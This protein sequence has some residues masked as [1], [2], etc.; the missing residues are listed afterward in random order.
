MTRCTISGNSGS[1]G[2]GLYSSGPLVMTSCT[3]SGNSSDWGGGVFSFADSV[4]DTSSVTTTFSDCTFSGN[5]ASQE[6]GGFCS[7]S[8]ASGSDSGPITT[9]FTDC[10]FS[11]N[12]A[13]GDFGGGLYISGE[14][15]ASGDAPLSTTLVNCTISGNT[16]PTG[17]GGLDFYDSVLAGSGSPITP[18]CVVQSTIIA[19]NTLTDTSPGPD[20]DVHDDG[21]GTLTS[22]GSNLI[23]TGN[24]DFI[25]GVEHDQIGTGAALLSPLLGTLASNGGLTQTLALLAG[26]PALDANFN[27]PGS[28]D[29]RGLPCPS[30]LR[31]DIGA[32]EHQSPVAAAYAFATAEGVAKTVSAATLFANASAPDAV[33]A[34]TAA[35]VTGPAHGTLTWNPD[36]SFT[37]TPT[38][39]FIGTDS[40]TYDINDGVMNSAPAT[41]TATVQSTGQDVT[42]PITTAA[43]NPAAP[44]GGNG[45]YRQPVTVTL[46]ATDDASGVASTFYSVNGGGQQ[47]YHGTFLLSADGVYTVS[48]HSVDTAEMQKRPKRFR[49]RSMR[50]HRS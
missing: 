4:S 36:G 9:T 23:G 14:D 8:G 43:L 29:E 6:G 25:N 26:S 46:A 47:T 5:S 31:G 16:A 17:G 44:T 12:S 41:V 34:L 45:Y 37:Y 21:Q 11:G 20:A 35:Q 40:L 42:P 1:Y 32:F 22:G 38:T 7:Y 24:G 30:G 28:T 33:G 27:T 19:G 49:S 10:T 15:D 50:R 3:I 39:G 18:T 2:G 13:S 48:Y